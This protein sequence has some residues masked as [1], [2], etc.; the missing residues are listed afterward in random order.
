ML[1]HKHLYA[2][3][4]HLINEI[5]GINLGALHADKHCARSCLSGVV[6]N[7]IYFHVQASLDQLIGKS[8]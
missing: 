4:R 5:M 7:F 1:G 8:L 3:L 2:C 6:H